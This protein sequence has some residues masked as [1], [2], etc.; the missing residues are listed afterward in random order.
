MDCRPQRFSRR[1]YAC[2]LRFC[3]HFD[4]SLITI[5]TLFWGYFCECKPNICAHKVHSSQVNVL[6]SIMPIQT[7]PAIQT[8]ELQM[9]RDI[10]LLRRVFLM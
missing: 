7:M 9:D 10:H 6:S 5:W 1:F 3:R 2:M 4:L 8:S